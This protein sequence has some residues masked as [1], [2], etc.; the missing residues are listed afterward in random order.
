MAGILR[1]R[2]LLWLPLLAA[3]GCGPEA[4]MAK[5][6]RM[7]PEQRPPDWDQTRQLMARRAP[8]V[9]EMAPDFTL[10]LMDGSKSVR[11]SEIQGGRPMMLVFGSF[12]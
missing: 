12:T 6:D 2:F 10:P 5:I 3:C 11:R 1:T 8:A 9:G 7:P 4:Y